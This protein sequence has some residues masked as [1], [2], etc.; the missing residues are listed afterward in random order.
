MLKNKKV[1]SIVV[2]GII[3][4]IAVTAYGYMTLADAM[5]VFPQDGFILGENSNIKDDKVDNNYY[6]SA[7]KKYQKKYP[8][9]VV[10]SDND[11]EKIVA[12]ETNFVHFRDE[13]LMALSDGVFLNTDTL[14]QKTLGYYNIG[15]DVILEKQNNDYIINSQGNEEKMRNFIWKLSD[16]KYMVVSP[17]VKM[18]FSQEKQ[19]T[20]EDYLEIEFV[21][22]GVVRLSHQDG[23][24]QTVSKDAYLE[25][26]NG[27]QLR[28]NNKT[29]LLEEKDVLT[30]A[31]MVID[32][33]DNIEVIEKE[34]EEV[35]DPEDDNNQ[36]TPDKNSPTSGGTGG[37]GGAG[38]AGG[39]GGTGGTGTSPDN[40][41]PG[42][43]PDDQDPSQDNDD[44]DGD[45][46]N[47]PTDPD[48]P[49]DNTTVEFPEFE[50]THFET[51][52]VSVSGT[53]EIKD[54]DGMLKNTTNV[55]IV[56]SGRNRVIY[57]N[58]FAEGSMNFDFGYEGLKPDTEYVVTVSGDYEYKDEE[59]HKD[60][61][62]KVFKT[63]D[64]GLTFK[65]SYVTSSSIGVEV[66]AQSYTLV[67]DAKLV[68]YKYNNAG[69]LE[70]VDDLEVSISDAVD[71]KHYVEVFEDGIESNTDYVVKLEEI[72]YGSTL[73][74]VSEQN[75]ELKMKTLKKS[76]II[77]Q[78]NVKINEREKTFT[79][80]N[81][82]VS[83][84]S[85]KTYIDTDNGIKNVVYEIYEQAQVT[86]DDES[87]EPILVGKPLKVIESKMI[88]EVNVDVDGV[89]LMPTTQYV[90]RQIVEFY[91]NEKTVEYVGNIVNGLTLDEV[92]TFPV[93]H[94][95][96]E[97]DTAGNI[98]KRHDAVVGTL[99]LSQT[100]DIVGNKVMIVVRSG[101]D[102][103]RT[104][105][106]E[107][108][109][110]NFE[111]YP[112]NIKGLT[113]NTYYHIEVYAR[114]KGHGGENNDYVY[115]GGVTEKTE[116]PPVVTMKVT[117]PKIDATQSRQ[118]FNFHVQLMNTVE[119]DKTIDTKD[120]IRTINSIDLSMYEED[121]L[122]NNQKV[123]GITLSD[124]NVNNNNAIND[125][126]P[127]EFQYSSNTM[128]DDYYNK[129]ENFDPVNL[130]VDTNNV[131]YYTLKISEPKDYCYD[132]TAS[133]D[134]NRIPIK[135]VVEDKNNSNNNGTIEK[136][137]DG[138][139]HVKIYTHGFLPEYDSSRHNVTVETITNGDVLAALGDYDGLQY[140]DDLDNDTI[141][142]LKV[143]G[144][145]PVNA[146]R[147]VKSVTYTVHT[148][149]SNGEFVKYA[150]KTVNY[151]ANQHGNNI[152]KYIFKINDGV[153]EE[154][155]EVNRNKG[156]LY[157]GHN[158]YVTYSVRMNLTGS[159]DNPAYAYFP[160]GN[161]D[162]Y[163]ESK[164]LNNQNATAILKQLP[165]IQMYVKSH[166]ETD[167]L[168]YTFKYRYTDID[169]AINN[170]I[171]KHNGK[172]VADQWTGNLGTFELTMADNQVN[173]IAKSVQLSFDEP[174]KDMNLRKVNINHIDA[175]AYQN[176]SFD[177]VAN[178]RDI[179]GVGRAV[180]ILNGDQ[181][182]IKRIATVDLMFTGVDDES[183][184]VEFKNVSLK[185]GKIDFP[186]TKL[187]AFKGKKAFTIDVK[188]HYDTGRIGTDNCAK[189]EFVIGTYIPQDD[190]STYA[191]GNSLLEAT[192]AGKLHKDLVLTDVFG[193]G[194]LSGT[195]I[196][197]PSLDNES[198]TSQKDY[199]F[200]TNSQGFK[201]GST[202]NED[203][204]TYFIPKV[205]EA[206]ELSENPQ[207]Y[208]FDYIYPEVKNVKSV[209]G[210]VDAKIT[211][212][213]YGT[214][215]SE[216]LKEKDGKSYIYLTLT[217]QGATESK[218]Y[219]IEIDKANKKDLTLNIPDEDNDQLKPNTQ[220]NYTIGV[221]FADDDTGAIHQLIDSDMNPPETKT[222]YFTTID[223]VVFENDEIIYR[224]ANR[225]YE[226]KSM[227]FTY[228]P[229]SKDSEDNPSHFINRGFY[230]EYTLTDSKG[231]KIDLG[232]LSQ[233]NEFFD[234]TTEVFQ[235][236]KDSL[237]GKQLN[238]GEKYTLTL[239]P[240]LINGGA[241]AGVAKNYDFTLD[242]LKEPFAM[243]MITPTGDNNNVAL[244]FS[245]S[246]SDENFALVNGDYTVS[247]YEGE[248][249][250]IQEDSTPLYQQAY[251]YAVS[252]ENNNEAVLEG[253]TGTIT[254]NDISTQT[255]D[256]K[257]EKDTAYTMVIRGLFDEKYTAIHEN[258]EAIE[259]VSSA[260]MKTRNDHGIAIGKVMVEKINNDST[261]QLVFYDS[262][263]LD[264]VTKIQYTIVD[265]KGS[266]QSKTIVPQFKQGGDQ[267][268]KTV[269]LGNNALNGLA[270]SRYTMVVHLQNDEGET[271][272]Q[273]RD[274]DFMISN[275]PIRQF[276]NFFGI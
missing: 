226:E 123:G 231:N 111:S 76:P 228:K 166:N 266:S 89:I 109:Q 153:L 124:M 182:L 160:Q 176:V 179:G 185:D 65:K 71:L 147:Y 45:N 192:A 38:G 82:P 265:A 103:T 74:N 165:E 142:G 152:P 236:G 70:K 49:E 30:L 235:V 88:N 254:H 60:F 39:T 79:F 87:G 85:N 13:S 155:D 19:E 218:V 20:V 98:V 187:N 159:D 91:D 86:I 24:Y 216:L 114:I 193:A 36:N 139:Y 12:D 171:L 28:L 276:M 105:T 170:S 196:S 275:N 18:H 244:D 134:S 208:S 67:N 22:K 118:P 247:I 33:D 7:G 95:T 213:Y 221:K 261:L 206:V 56:E 163:D 264:Q 174:T 212:D 92:S 96:K 55:K 23:M 251:H 274:L 48:I 150:S 273:I 73:I 161:T 270:P 224:F 148:K 259:W 10:F 120:V 47:T 57:D 69:D 125:S 72:Q 246:I 240:R 137:S 140:R 267:N 133:K 31:Q 77:G 14:N 194:V 262:L 37:T 222:Y 234:P 177:F 162:T 219:K 164:V 58:D 27:V 225:N 258:G 190:A 214:D 117:I 210:L 131:E 52:L 241:E 121:R 29:L 81:E 199:L 202:A 237:I 253:N 178:D 128:I 115:I 53:V 41:T 195:H 51:T 243:K 63:D 215:R 203:M 44:N 227:Q 101:T 157:R 116:E 233:R 184:K 169:R 136:D 146:I 198:V 119:D 80:Y 242:L 25:L 223:E 149:D 245:W 230:I 144:A 59:Y 83:D 21:D 197:N 238:F 132:Y 239:Q 151:D 167:N 17:S 201:H 209:A 102:R 172:E 61:I 3:L 256:F 249:Y 143:N 62:T 156:E 211:F 181:E 263:G 191:L 90:Y 43:Q 252:Y 186:L 204:A 183:Q 75:L 104:L 135:V 15:N 42:Q 4:I 93:V 141:V 158:Y 145:F 271:L 2:I 175:S 99:S 126:K 46:S 5:E 207:E 1:L 260:T 200:K 127:D 138:T 229:M 11:G 188:V 106:W 130:K 68:L 100:N 255:P 272:A 16:S 40:S 26:S 268:I 107:V 78:S 269:L 97:I 50:M 205:V 180:I 217:E 9:K 35:K 94:W 108:E 257:F 54:N 129:Y 6:F 154:S 173:T 122:S 232:D 168:K 112:I 64:L 84:Q 248:S 220:Y 250:D 189:N 110:N 66:K 34:K 113:A 8:N 32:S